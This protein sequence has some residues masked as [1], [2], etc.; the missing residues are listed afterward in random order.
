[1]D[2]CVV[3]ASYNHLERILRDLLTA[4]RIN[5]CAPREGLRK[6]GHWGRTRAKTVGLRV[7]EIG[8]FSQH[9][10]KLFDRI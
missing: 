3:G 7:D 1:M 2:L 6:W 5:E 8:L 9:K 4:T 10:A